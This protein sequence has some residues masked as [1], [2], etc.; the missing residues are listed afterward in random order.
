VEELI[1]D[2]AKAKDIGRNAYKHV[3][4]NYHISKMRDKWMRVFN[5][6]FQRADEHKFVLSPDE[7]ADYEEMK[8]GNPID[9]IMSAI[10]VVTSLKNKASFKTQ[11]VPRFKQ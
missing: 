4:E 2:P 8:Q 1:A 7:L 6:L 5:H 11:F 9:E 3:Q 10:D